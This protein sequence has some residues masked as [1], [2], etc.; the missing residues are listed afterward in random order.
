MH[1]ECGAKRVPIEASCPTPHVTRTHELLDNLP[2][3]AMLLLGAAICHTTVAGPAWGWLAAG[4]YLAYGLAGAFWIMLF[5]CP[6]CQFYATRRCPC[7]YGRI[8][9]RLRPRQAGDRFR[10]QFRKH[11]PVI[12]PLW[13][14]PLIPGGVALARHFSWPLLALVLAFAVDAFAILPLVSRWYGCA[15]CPQESTCPWMAGGRH[16]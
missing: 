14:L 2:Y 4:G 9:A 12:T 10:A 11:I 3:L 16:A 5:V 6:Y 1:E 7:G 15:Q 13:F 8:A